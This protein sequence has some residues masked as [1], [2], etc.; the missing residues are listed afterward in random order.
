[1]R[2]RHKAQAAARRRLTPR[3]APPRREGD[4]FELWL[5]GRLKAAYDD[6]VAEPVPP[7]LL[8]L[9]GKTRG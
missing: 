1:V 2:T 8:R 7:D 6:V 5:R 9:I 3:P 4:A